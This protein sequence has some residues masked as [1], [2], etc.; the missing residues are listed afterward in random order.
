MHARGCTW[1]A[2]ALAGLCPTLAGAQAAARRCTALS[3]PP[4]AA[5]PDAS[6][7][8]ESSV[9]HQAGPYAPPAMPGGPSA[10]PLSLPEHCEVIGVLHERDGA[11]GQRY[12]IHFHLRLPIQ[13]NGGFFFQGGGGSDG[14]LGDALGLTSNVAP[15]ALSQGYAVVSQDSGHDNASNSDPARGGAVAFGFDPQARA[16]YGGTSLKVVADTAK[17]V[18]R[19]FYGRAAE[20]AYF[21]GCSKGGQEGMVFAQRH[22]EEFDGILA[23]A[24]GFSLPRAAVAEAWDVQSIAAIG[25][26]DRSAGDG[27]REFGNAY[28]TADLQLVAG[29]IL[30]VCDADDGVSDGLIGN[31][32]ACTAK[33]VVPVLE[34]LQCAA[35]KL[36]ACLASDQVHALIRIFN[37]PRDARGTPLYSA[38]QWDAGM[39]APGW[40]VWK[41]GSEDHRVPALNIALG[42]SSLAAVFTTPPTAVNVDLA[43]TWNYLSTFDFDRDAPKIYSGSAEFTRSAWSDMSARSPDLDAFR[44]HGGKLIVPHGVSDPVFSILDTLAWFREI[45]HR[46]HGQADRFVRVF[47]VPGMNHCGGGPATDHYDAF[48]SLTEWVE[49]GMAPER[50]LASAGDQSPWPG[51]SRP[52]CPYPKIA[53]FSGHGSVES[54]DSFACRVEKAGGQSKPGTL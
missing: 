45:D 52:L 15:P 19:T 29:S 11:A 34:K 10:A 53:F 8:I 35:D 39:A 49:R 40:R 18:I 5:W 20:R 43:S 54:A 24:P 26:S 32:P 38:W 22:P 44:K 23:S 51:R 7:R 16:D 3:Q 13:W 46:T 21:V 36:P 1:V 41:L 48:K 9:F 30:S 25:K 42:G 27:L 6:T 47:P 17:A 14:V 31:F 50:I 4:A 33:R 12:A 37:G 2:I 28:T